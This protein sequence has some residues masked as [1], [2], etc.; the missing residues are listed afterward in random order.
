MFGDRPFSLTVFGPCC[1]FIIDFMTEA[2]G[3]CKFEHGPHLARGSD[4]GPAWHKV[5]YI[6]LVKR[7]NTVNASKLDKSSLEIIRLDSMLQ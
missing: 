4:F 5:T 6:S 2:V 3:Q 7:Q 1:L